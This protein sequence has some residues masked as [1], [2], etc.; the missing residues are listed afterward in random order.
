MPARAGMFVLQAALCLTLVYAGW[1]AAHRF[2]LVTPGPY[3]ERHVLAALPD[4]L[5]T[6]DGA[7]LL[8]A[9]PGDRLAYR[10]QY[11]TPL[12][13]QA[14]RRALLAS[15]GWTPSVSS[16]PENVELLRI[17]AD[18]GAN[19]VARFTLH[20]EGDS[21]SIIVEFSPLPRSL[22]PPQP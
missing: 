8:D 13:V 16:A 9:G 12:P 3:S 22:A 21:T 15:P 5:P 17:D 10:L 14:V 7:R 19:F 1:L 4:D 20:D 11:D 6:V 2:T 18:R